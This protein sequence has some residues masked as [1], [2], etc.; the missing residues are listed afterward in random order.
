MRLLS[1]LHTA[2]RKLEAGLQWSTA[3]AAVCFFAVVLIG[4]LSRYALQRPLLAS[5]ELSRLFFVWACF[6][7][8]A[9][10]YRRRAHVAFELLFEQLPPGLQYVL[11]LLGHALVLLFCSIVGVA[12][13][14]VTWWV[15]QTGLPMLGASMG[16]FFLPVPLVCCVMMFFGVE[17]MAAEVRRPGPAT[18]TPGGY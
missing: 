7:A 2:N 12:G 4:V 13:V 1:L 11:T 14:R 3:G 8:A 18:K 9:L 5:I 15:W 16:W 6:L 10:A 17:N